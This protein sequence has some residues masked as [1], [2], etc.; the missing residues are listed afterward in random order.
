MTIGILYLSVI[1]LNYPFR[2]Q[3]RSM[4]KNILKLKLTFTKDFW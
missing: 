2:V 4:H 3:C 1:V